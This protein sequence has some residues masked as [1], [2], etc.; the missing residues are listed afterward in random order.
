MR[1]FYS[2]MFWVFIVTGAIS[3]F[4]QGFKNASRPDDNQTNRNRTG[5][6]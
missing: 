2:V 3:G 1:D 5:R 6:R 4:C